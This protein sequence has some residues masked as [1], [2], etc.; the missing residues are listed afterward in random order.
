MKIFFTSIPK[1]HHSWC[2]CF[3]FQLNVCCLSTG[4]PVLGINFAGLAVF[5]RLSASLTAIIAALAASK[6]TY[7][8]T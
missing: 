1:F 7:V 3:A 4:L 6:D 2:L 8:I 5:S